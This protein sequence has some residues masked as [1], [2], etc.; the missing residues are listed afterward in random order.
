MKPDE[1]PQPDEITKEEERITFATFVNQQNLQLIGSVD[2]K[3]SIIVGINGTILG[4]L[5]QSISNI[6]RI[7][8]Q[9]E[10]SISSILFWLTVSLLGLS[11][12][13]GVWTL[14]PKINKKGPYSD[15]KVFHETIV[16]DQTIDNLKKD[17]SKFDEVMKNKVEEYENELKSKDILHEEAVNAFRLAYALKVRHFRYLRWSLRFLLG[18]LGSLVTFL[19]YM[20]VLA[21]IGKIQAANA[22][23]NG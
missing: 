1:N 12:S 13:F 2:T 23:I 15:S 5:A 17:K 22:N 4:L 19:L 3:T 18:G 7:A 16:N 14:M 9:T 21:Y 10:G 20:S 8:G 11:A 6:S